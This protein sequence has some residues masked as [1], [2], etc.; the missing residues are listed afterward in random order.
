LLRSVMAGLPLFPPFPSCMLDQ[1]GGGILQ[2]MD[3]DV[4]EIA[5]ATKG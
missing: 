4:I 5:G 2:F 1:S 3:N